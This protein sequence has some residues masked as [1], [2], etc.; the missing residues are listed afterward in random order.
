MKEAGRNHPRPLKV[1][2]YM[3]HAH[4]NLCRSSPLVFLFFFLVCFR[5]SVCDFV[6]PHLFLLLSCF[7]L[8]DVSFFFVLADWLVGRAGALLGFGFVVAALGPQGTGWLSCGKI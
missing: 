8:H 2:G 3:Y 6:F 5:V 7:V 4:M 1:C